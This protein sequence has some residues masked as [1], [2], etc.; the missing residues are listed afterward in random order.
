MSIKVG[1]LGMGKAAQQVHCPTIIEHDGFQLSSIC[2]TNLDRCRFAEESYGVKTYQDYDQ[3][4]NGSN[5]DL[6]V[7][8]TPTNFHRDHTIKAID[9]GKHVVVEKPM[10][11]NLAEADEMIEGAE[12]KG[13][14]LTVHQSRRWDGDYLTIKKIL[15]E[16]RLGKVFCIE[17]RMVRFGS[18]ERYAVKEFD[19][20]WRL[21]KRFGGGCL[22]DFGSH[23]I[24]QI[25]LLV[26]S[27]VRG[28]FCDMKGILW[29]KE[30]DDYFKLLL[31]FKDGTIAQVE[32]SDVSR[33]GLPRWYILGDDGALIMKG[34]EMK[35]KRG[36][37]NLE[38]IVELERND[39]VCFYHNLYDCLVHGKE[40]SVKP[41]QVRKVVQIIDAAFRSSKEKKEVRL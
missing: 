28:V 40:L 1:I 8:A 25:L 21:K 2:D 13:V 6:V 23:L 3:F 35:I 34:K 20:R 9:S 16:G 24:D 11:L 18:V 33:Y 17:S 7:V 14:I 5:V 27:E 37:N 22:Y 12:R 4:L 39:W 41:L 30:V 32:R 15:K 36:K 38:E 31:R 29:S 10:A 19:P 26:D